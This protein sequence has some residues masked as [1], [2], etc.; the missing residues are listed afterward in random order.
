MSDTTS[1]FITLKFVA[2]ELE[3]KFTRGLM[4]IDRNELILDTNFG[5]ANIPAEVD[6]EKILAL[7]EMQF[8]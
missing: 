1:D 4:V 5:K 6:V 7:K 3:G 8:S 2:V